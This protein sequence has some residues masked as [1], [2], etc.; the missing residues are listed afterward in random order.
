MR[1]EN[2]NTRSEQFSN[3]VSDTVIASDHQIMLKLPEMKVRNSKSENLIEQLK[4]KLTK[5]DTIHAQTI[6]IIA[7][8]LRSPFHVILGSLELIK[9]K[10]AEFH[11]DDLDT[12]I[13]MAS[14]S[15]IRT[16]KLLDD[17]LQWTISQQKSDKI[18][19]PIKLNLYTLVED[20]MAYLTFSSEHK[21]LSIN[22]SIAPDLNVTADEQMVKTI[23]RN[24]I[25]NAIKFTNPG[26]EIAISASECKQFV[27]IIVSDTGIG[28]SKEVQKKL[29]KIETMH[30]TSGT[31]NEH[32]SGF[33]LILCKKFVEMHGGSLS[34]ISEP[35]K[36]S[37]FIFTLPHYI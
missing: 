12:Y 5:S 7:H 15:A 16:L 29:F 23:L 37:K 1:R 2:G 4:I 8:D 25:G 18:L 26:D 6:S 3:V 27:E 35:G 31:N 32:G 30:S 11:I 14:D 36:G 22:H 34:V 33:G 20:E 24:L 9:M 28:I 13:G 17:L 10:L 19:N 21:L